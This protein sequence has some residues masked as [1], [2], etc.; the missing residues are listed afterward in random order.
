MFMVQYTLKYNSSVCVFDVLGAIRPFNSQALD[1]GVRRAVQHFRR[2]GR[3]GSVHLKLQVRIRG[4]EEIGS[5]LC[6]AVCIDSSV[7]S[8]T[9]FLFLAY[10][11]GDAYHIGRRVFERRPVVRVKPV[12]GRKIKVNYLVFFH[13]FCLLT[14]V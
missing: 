14:F 10:I 3:S 1:K 5:L 8:V 6:T 11:Q 13:F 7:Y 9:K 2:S 4:I 12:Y